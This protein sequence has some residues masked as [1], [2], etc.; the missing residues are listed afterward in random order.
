MSNL[1]LTKLLKK[2]QGH[3]FMI[4]QLLSMCY[5]NDVNASVHIYFSPALSCSFIIPVHPD[6]HIGI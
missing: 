2:F 5:L 4:Q 1:L 3:P 6:I